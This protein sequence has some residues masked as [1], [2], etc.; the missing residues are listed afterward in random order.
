MEI[1]NVTCERKLFGGWKVRILWAECWEWEIL[2]K[3]GLYHHIALS[4]WLLNACGKS[5]SDELKEW[6]NELE[7]ER[8]GRLLKQGV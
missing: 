3:V 4:A 8:E 7:R 6:K 1:L 5:V 2:M